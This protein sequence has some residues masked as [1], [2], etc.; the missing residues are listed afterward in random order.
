[1]DPHPIPEPAEIP[2]LSL[3][4]TEQMWEMLAGKLDEFYQ[5]WNPK[6]P[7]DLQKFLP[8]EAGQFRR[9][10]LIELIKV[11]ME[12]RLESGLTLRRLREYADQFPELVQRGRLEPDLL[13]EEIQLRKKH[14]L[15]VDPDEYAS[16]LPGQLETVRRLIDG[17]TRARTSA[18]RPRNLESI[19]AGGEIDD[20]ELLMELGKGAFATVYLA[21]QKSMQRMV[22]LKISSDRGDEPKT[23]AQ[24]DCKNIVR[25]YDVRDI[26]DPPCRLLYMRFV[27]GGSL[28]DVVARMRALDPDQR[29]GRALLA[30]I[31]E[32]AEKTGQEVPLESMTRQRLLDRE[33]FEVVCWFGAEIAEGL[34]YA[35]QRGVLHRDLKPANVLL[36][37]EGI[38]QIVD[39]NV[40][41]CSDIEGTTAEAFFGGSLAYMS[42]EQLEAF[43]LAHPRKPEELTPASDIYSLGIILWELL[44]GRRPFSDQISGNDYSQMLTELRQQRSEF[45]IIDHLKEETSDGLVPVLAP[46][47]S[48]LLDPDPN[49]RIQDAGEIAGELSLLANREMRQLLRPTP[50]FWNRLCYRHLVWFVVLAV[51]VPSALAAVFNYFYNFDSIIRPKGPEVVKTFQQV[52]TVINAIA[53]PVGIGILVWLSVRLR[54]MLKR[55]EHNRCG[56]EPATDE[57]DIPRGIPSA[58]AVRRRVLRSPLVAVFVPLSIWT[59]CGLAYPL[60]MS[61][62]HAPISTADALHFLTSLILCGLIASVYPFFLVSYVA[63]RFWYPVAFR[64]RDLERSDIVRIESLINRVWFFMLLGVMLPTFS[65]LLIVA[66]SRPNNQLYLAILA[67]GSLVALAVVFLVFQKLQKHLETVRNTIESILS[68]SIFDGKSSFGRGQP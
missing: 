19:Q 40:S 55:M 24:L 59:V 28:H 2:T 36:S 8:E 6:A 27:S 12:L 18:M 53:F 58:I 9:F 39:F 41:F 56:E 22:A 7:P 30:V 1:M 31:D 49:R 65:I 45:R 4:N 60:A 62:R 67:G 3:Q 63:I 43:D 54:Q 29:N 44:F 16:W 34:A 37:V 35:H 61:L 47:F 48:G 33:W 46:V 52:Q 66:N 21:R 38:P 5:A 25:V 13:F 10:S 23:L 64:C 51:V 42:P 50:G 14:A 26:D 17:G 11:D 32:Q 57:S 15:P 20:F 68:N